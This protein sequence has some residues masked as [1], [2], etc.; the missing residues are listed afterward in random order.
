MHWVT[1]SESA[2]GIKSLPQ[3][4]GEEV[5]TVLA[6]SGLESD[7]THMFDQFDVA[8]DESGCVI[9]YIVLLTEGLDV[10]L[11]FTI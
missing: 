9:P 3:N 1:S 2:F 4:T 6:A 11:H 7:I 5:L 8:I 10:R